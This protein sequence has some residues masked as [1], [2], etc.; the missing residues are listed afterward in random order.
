MKLT[1]IHRVL[2]FRQS[3]WMQKNIDFNTKKTM[4]AANS[5]EKNFFKL[6]INSVYGKAMENLR[7]RIMS[8]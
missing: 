5:F 3:D 1:Q 2:R 4:N 8:D 6:I 7:K